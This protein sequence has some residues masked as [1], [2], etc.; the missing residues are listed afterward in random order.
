M[1]L[2]AEEVKVE[3]LHPASGFEPTVT[4]LEVRWDPLTGD[5]SRVLPPSGLLSPQHDDLAPLAVETQAQ[6]PF[7]SDRIETAVPRFPPGILPEG[8]VRVGEAVLFPNLSPQ[9]QYSSV[10]VY[11]PERHFL[12]LNQL[13][14]RLVADNLATQVAFDRAVLASDPRASWAS[15]NANHLLPS[16]SSIF[17]SISRAASTRPRPTSDASWRPFPATATPTTWPPNAA[18]ADAGWVNS[19]GSNGWPRSPRAT[20]GPSFPAAPHLQPNSSR[21]GNFS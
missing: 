9:S 8:R 20:S 21:R 17:H 15:V 18:S 3:I 7:C 12:I 10:S 19:A 13:T 1:E 5:T 14:P 11:S 6:C 4:Q 16:G 2:R